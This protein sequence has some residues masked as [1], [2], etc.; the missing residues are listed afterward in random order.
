MDEFGAGFI[1]GGWTV[2]GESCD[3]WSLDLEKVALLVEDSVKFKHLALWKEIKFDRDYERSHLCRW[4]HA[5]APIDDTH[6]F[7]YGG[8]DKDRR[9]VHT[10]FVF[11]AKTHTIRQMAETGTPP[12]LRMHS[13][14]LSAGGDTVIMYGGVDPAGDKFFSDLWHLRVDLRDGDVHYVKRNYKT[15][16]YHL[17]FSWRHGFTLHNLISFQD[18][19]LIGGNFGNGQ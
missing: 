8:V 13:S 7:I 11:D 12:P 15:K 17:I 19:V 2:H 5:S 14:M 6:I 10:S 9:P 3:I 16:H 4:G 1:M 18:P